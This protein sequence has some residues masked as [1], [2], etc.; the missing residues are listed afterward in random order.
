MKLKRITAFALVFCLLCGMGSAFALNEGDA[1]AVIGADLTDD[2]KASVYSTFGVTRGNVTELTVTNAEERQYLDGLVSSDK[3]G[4][5]SI[6]CVYVQITSAGSGLDITVSDNISWCTRETYLNALVTAGIT[7]A[8]VIVTAPISGITGTAALTGVYKAYE[9]ITGETLDE[10]AKAVGT[11]ELVIT[12]D[13]AN[14]IGSYDASMIVNELKKILD[15]T[16]EMSDDQVRTEI[17]KIAG[18]FS[19]SITDGQV[20][21]LLKLCRSLEGLDSS[22]LQAQ[23][24]AAQETIKKLAGVQETASGFVEGVKSFFK[25]IGDFFANLFGSKS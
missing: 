10:L 12:S 21:Q 6:S 16:E 4:T 8:K 23:V 15:E 9:S 17:Q 25:A 2:Q 14:E 20:E 24:E 3:I 19:V 11:Q 1:R 18:D 22:A 13:L 5:R 7:D